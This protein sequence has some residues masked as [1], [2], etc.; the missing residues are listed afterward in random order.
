MD[1]RRGTPYPHAYTRTDGY[2]CARTH[3]YTH[4]TSSYAYTAP[5]DRPLGD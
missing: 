1:S 2:S 5:A 3:S 4:A